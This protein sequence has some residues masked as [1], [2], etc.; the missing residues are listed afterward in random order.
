MT[1]GHTV[2]DH[3]S[4]DRRSMKPSQTIDVAI[5]GGGPAGLQATLV[6]ARTRKSVVVFDPPRPP[7][8][9]ASHGVHNFVGLDGLLPREIRD[10]AWSQIDAYQSAQLVRAA[11]TTIERDEPSGGLVLSADGEQW[12]AREVVLACGYDDRHPPIDGFAE[13][14][15][16]TII[17]CPFC[18]GFENRDRVWGI[19]P[20]MAMELDYFPEMVQN[21]TERRLVI[22]PSTFD[23]TDDQRTML[24][25]L[26]VPLHVGDIV[27]IDHLDGKVRS[28]TLDSGE[29]VE[30]ET[31]LWTPPE[32]PTALVEQLV[33]TLGLE[34][35]EHGY[36]TVDDHQRTN[37][38]R[39]WAAG[40]VQGWMG[41]IESA[42]AGSMAAAMI[43][44]GW[45]A[46]DR[47]DVA[48]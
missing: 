18:D 47:Q 35:D 28:V 1:T 42:S 14:W 41:A 27:A 40:D 19:V 12:L 39:L 15:A 4:V 17:P 38:A 11:V 8:N 20:T 30:V 34:L 3:Q 13:C 33:D 23:V 46:D 25:K 37:V 6:L 43:V 45:Y 32:A 31:L 5:I 26:D 36:V 7:R 24:Q 22:A 10:Q 16:D 44:H 9:G 29:V 48:A 21:W 2:T